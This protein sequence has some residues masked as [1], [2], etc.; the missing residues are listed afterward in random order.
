LRA[1]RRRPHRPRAS[2]ASRRPQR[3]LRP[4]PGGVRPPGPLHRRR[5]ARAAHAAGGHPRPGAVGAEPAALGRGVPRDGRNLPTRRGAEALDGLVAEALPLVGPLA[6]G[7]DVR[8]SAETS[9]VV[10]TGDREG[11][12]RVVNNLLTNAVQYNRPGGAVRVHLAAEGG[13]A[14][15]TVA[16]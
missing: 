6:E 11:L 3:H 2:R 13:M 8:L 5:L 9:P 4:A 10:V 7:K 15:L 16:D 1:H 12:M 14:V